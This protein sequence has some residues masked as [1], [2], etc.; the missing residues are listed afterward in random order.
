MLM[1]WAVK[2]LSFSPLTPCSVF[3][4][5]PLVQPLWREVLQQLLG[6]WAGSSREFPPAPNPTFRPATSTC[7]KPSAAQVC[8]SEGFYSPTVFSHY[9]FVLIKASH[10]S[11]IYAFWNS[12][13]LKQPACMSSLTWL[14]VLLNFDVSSLDQLQN[15]QI[16]LFWDVF[17]IRLLAPCSTGGRS[18]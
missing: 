15:M 4:D 8:R 16:L 7:R 11:F 18:Y 17:F 10:S 14:G 3:R 6:V 12:L 13:V 1:S 9:F 5:V 2:Q